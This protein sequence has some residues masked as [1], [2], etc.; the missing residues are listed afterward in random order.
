M[1]L[2]GT[3]AFLDGVDD[4]VETFTSDSEGYRLGTNVEY[5]L[6][7]EFGASTHPGTPHFRPGMDATQAKMAQLAVQASN[8]DEFLKLTAYQWQSEV[9]SRSPVDTGNLRASYT[10]E[11]R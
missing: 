3:A 5:A 1:D 6:A 7:Q 2:L 11:E 9:Q 10:V 8:L 4:M